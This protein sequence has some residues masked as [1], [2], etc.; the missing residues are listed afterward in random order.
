MK[1]SKVELIKYLLNKDRYVSAQEISEYIAMSSKTVSRYV[2]DLDSSLSA[3]NIKIVSAKGLGY[4]LSGDDESIAKLS[5]D[6]FKNENN[7]LKDS[8][9]DRVKQLLFIIFNEKNLTCKQISEKMAISISRLRYYLELAKQKALSLGVSI[10]LD[11]SKNICFSASEKLKRNL[12]LEL[13]I[14]LKSKDVVSVIK[15]ISI[16]EIN[17]IKTFIKIALKDSETLLSDQDVNLVLKLLIVSISRLKN[18]F[19]VEESEKT[20]LS[21]VLENIIN[22]IEKS[23]AIQIADGERYYLQSILG[24]ILPTKKQV[25]KKISSSELRQEIFD[26]LYSFNDFSEMEYYKDEK[27]ISD[28]LFHIE[29]FIDREKDLVWAS[30]PI[31]K[32]VKENVPVEFNLAYFLCDALNKKYNYSITEDEIGFIAMYFALYE[33]RKRHEKKKKVAIICHYGLGSARLLQEKIMDTFD[34]IDEVEIFPEVFKDMVYEKKFDIVVSSVPLGD[35][36]S[37]PVIYVNNIF[38]GELLAKLEE[39]LKIGEKTTDELFKSLFLPSAFFE[40]EAKNPIELIEKLGKELCKKGLSTCEVIDEVIKREAISST[41]I[42]NNV[43]IPHALSEKQGLSIIAVAKLKEAII[44]GDDQ[45]RLVFLL[46][47]SS[48]DKKSIKI[49]K[50]LYYFLK[51]KSKIETLLNKTDYENLMNLMEEEEV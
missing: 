34:E 29:R 45:V 9:E 22:K 46:C 25:K 1:K 44:W 4:K 3:Y 48:R 27:L 20:E 11:D 31:L 47:F 43:A 42:G 12:L 30:N 28:L 32:D 24:F 23:F 19:K 40:I 26:I 6:I 37:F 16:D 14:K 36:F 51:D 39:K 17:S 33:R 2:K 10:D 41:N 7:L 38:S 49:F 35:N 50:S 15:N 5:Y 21:Q 18:G 13:I 8:D